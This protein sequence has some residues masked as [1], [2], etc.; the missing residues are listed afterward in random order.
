MKQAHDPRIGI[1]TSAIAKTIALAGLVYA[2]FLLAG[3]LPLLAAGMAQA[4][5]ASA[6]IYTGLA[7]SVSSGALLGITCAATFVCAHK[8]SEA[9]HDFASRQAAIKQADARGEYPN[10]PPN[11]WLDPKY[12]PRPFTIKAAKFMGAAALVAGG[13]LLVN[14]VGMSLV[15]TPLV[16]DL[17]EGAALLLVGHA[18]WKSAHGAEEIVM[19]ARD[20]QQQEQQELAR[21]REK[22]AHKQLEKQHEQHHET[23]KPAQHEAHHT[24]TQPAH[25]TESASPKTK[26]EH[27]TLEEAHKPT[28]ASKVQR[29]EQHASHAAKI[30]AE[31][32]N[33]AHHQ[34]AAHL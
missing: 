20:A 16:A 22:Q 27:S 10:L 9:Y 19:F 26:A 14:L 3:G 30:M 1:T 32:Q 8:T 34:H 18:T 12:E 21:I 4:T 29:P 7:S 5:T 2:G 23:V 15:G 6:A 11:K 33:A 24:T 25:T 17:I 31:K 28:H 13:A